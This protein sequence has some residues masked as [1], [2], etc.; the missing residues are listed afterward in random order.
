MVSL[1]NYT[2]TNVRAS[3]VEGK[4]KANPIANNAAAYDKL[5][6]DM[7]MSSIGYQFS[8]G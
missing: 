4:R 1:N 5:I 2:L 7:P 3:R 6:A 8:L